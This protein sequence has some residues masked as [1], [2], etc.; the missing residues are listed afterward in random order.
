MERKRTHTKP[1]DEKARHEEQRKKIM[2]TAQAK[3]VVDYWKLV[4]T[5]SG[6]DN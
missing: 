4:S 3:L 6:D 2:V 5:E 1:Q